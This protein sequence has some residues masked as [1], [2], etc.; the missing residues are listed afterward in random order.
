MTKISLEQMLEAGL[1]FGHQTFRWNPKMRQ[2][3]FEARDG[4]HIIDLT[5]T[6]ARLKEALDFVSQVAKEGKLLLF[7][8]TKRQAAK[9]IEEQAKAFNLPYISTKWPGGLLTNFKTI[10]KRINYL[11]KV[12]DKIKTEDYADMTKKEI[13]LLKKELVRLEEAF[14]GLDKLTELPGAVFVVDVCQEKTAIK[15]AIKLGIPVIAMVDTNGDPSGIEFV[16]PAND[17]AK[18]GIT[19]ITQALAETFSNNYKA[20]KLEAETKPENVNDKPKKI[21]KP[22]PKKATPKTDSKKEETNN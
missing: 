9:I 18:S 16:I 21:A 13:G 15:E 5:Q 3:I 14:G 7:L 11:K 8:G 12:R 4:V 19:L 17:D 1:H 22:K 6:E 20:P 2:Y 10:K